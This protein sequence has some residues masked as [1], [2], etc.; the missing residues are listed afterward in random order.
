MGSLP[1]N[2]GATQVA[3]DPAKPERVYALNETALFRSADAG[4]TWQPVGQ[5]L[6]SQDLTALAIDPKQPERLY[7][8]AVDGAL[9]QS[10]DEA[11]TWEPLATTSTH[12]TPTP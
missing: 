6:P 2:A 10:E 4:E 3:I 12:A 9:F 1:A 8:A 11:A 5:G 7:V